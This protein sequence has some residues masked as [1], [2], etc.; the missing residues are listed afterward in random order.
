MTKDNTIGA[1]DNGFFQRSDGLWENGNGWFAVSMRGK[2]G[3]HLEETQD[4]DV[5]GF[6]FF[7]YKADF[8]SPT[9]EVRWALDS[10]VLVTEFNVAR[11][12]VRLG[13]AENVTEIEIASVPL[14][15][16]DE[17]AEPDPEASESADPVTADLAVQVQ[18]DPA[19]NGRAAVVTRGDPTAA[20]GNDK[21]PEAPAGAKPATRK[22]AAK[23]SDA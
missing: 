21:Q 23:K 20:R 15:V 1:L 16:P 8:N 19:E 9:T 2:S 4:G 12:L 13:Y 18:P 10:K 17:P 11:T 14:I 7:R 6:N 22:K 3:D 5:T